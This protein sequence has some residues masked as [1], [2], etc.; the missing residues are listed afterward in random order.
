MRRTLREVDPPGCSGAWSRAASVVGHRP[1]RH[2]SVAAAH[3]SLVLFEEWAVAEAHV[4]STEGLVLHQVLLERG[5]L[6][7]AIIGPADEEEFAP[8]LMR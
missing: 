8:R 2:A 6:A 7:L 1:R 4:E 3:P 5:V